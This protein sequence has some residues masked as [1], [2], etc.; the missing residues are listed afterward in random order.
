[1]FEFIVGFLF[2][3]FFMVGFNIVLML[4][5]LGIKP[6]GF[7]DLTFMLGITKFFDNKLPKKEGG[8]KKWN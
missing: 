4:N 8:K 2:G 7:I 1:M 5:M 6:L 3:I